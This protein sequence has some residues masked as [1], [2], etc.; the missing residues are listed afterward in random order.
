[1]M[2]LLVALALVIG[3]CRAA[4]PVDKVVELIQE[5]KAKIEADGKA[6]QK[7]YDKFACWCERTTASK[8][9]AMTDAKKS[10]ERLSEKVLGLKGKTANF[11]ADIKQLQKDIAA[12]QD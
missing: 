1:M 6:E 3:F 10:I 5:L 4:S 9:K 11:A 12:N 8:A 7:V 2:K